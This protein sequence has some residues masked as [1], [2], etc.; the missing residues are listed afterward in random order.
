MLRD[1]DE[2]HAA[3]VV[4]EILTF[5]TDSYARDSY[6]LDIINYAMFLSKKGA[7]PAKSEVKVHVV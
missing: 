3:W 4:L 1:L 7:T 5:C 6:S 2:S